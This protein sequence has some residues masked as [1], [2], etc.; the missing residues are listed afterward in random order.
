MIFGPRGDEV[1]GGLVAGVGLRGTP[2]AEQTVGP[3]IE[4]AVPPDGVVFWQAAAV[5]VARSVEPRGQSGRN[6]PGRDVARQPG[7]LRG[8]GMPG[9]G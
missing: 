8:E 2:G 3:A 6:A 7:R 4:D 1:G 9:P 5:V